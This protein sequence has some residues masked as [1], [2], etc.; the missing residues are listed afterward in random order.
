MPV[1]ASLTSF[2]LLRQPLQGRVFRFKLDH[3]LPQTVDF[4]LHVVVLSLHALE[5]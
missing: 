5:V 1:E 4:L 3:L 2:M